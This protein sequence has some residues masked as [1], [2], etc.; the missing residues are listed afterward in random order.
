MLNRPLFEE[1]VDAHWITLNPRMATDRFRDHHTHERMLFADAARLT[2]DF[3]SEEEIPDFDPAEREKLDRLFGRYGSWSWTGISLHERIAAV[4]RLWGERREAL[5]FH[6]RIVHRD[7]NQQLHLS[8]QA[9]NQMVLRADVEGLYVK[10]GPGPE[11]LTRALASAFWTFGEMLGLM[12]D[13]FEIPAQADFASAY[14]AGAKAF[15]DGPE[16][17]S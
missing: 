7:N 15:E 3:V 14:A 6:W 9:M 17:S 11:Y 8:G 2:P 12:L 4:G 16:A 13:Y 10:L 5:D 1:M